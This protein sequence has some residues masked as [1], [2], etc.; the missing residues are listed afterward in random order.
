MCL[1][2]INVLFK[3]DFLI[4]SINS[5]FINIKNINWSVI[6]WQ[7]WEGIEHRV[8]IVKKFDI[9][10]NISKVEFKIDSLYADFNGYTEEY[11]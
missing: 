4:N 5:H 11:C 10:Q 7:D 6:D 1:N 9:S 8:S 2:A 3:I